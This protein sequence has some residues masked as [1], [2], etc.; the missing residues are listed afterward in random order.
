MTRRPCG[1]RTDVTVFGHESYCRQIQ[2]PGDRHKLTDESWAPW[3][4]EHPEEVTA[5]KQAAE[6]AAA[7]A[8]KET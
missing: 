3:R 8:K 2:V 5:M 4:D 7:A 6:G 1:C